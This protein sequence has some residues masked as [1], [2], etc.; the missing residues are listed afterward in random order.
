MR[1]NTDA[2]TDT[3]TLVCPRIH[4]VNTDKLGKCKRRK[5]RRTHMQAPATNTFTSA[6]F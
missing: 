3:D 5:R 4:F 2:H 6:K 1:L